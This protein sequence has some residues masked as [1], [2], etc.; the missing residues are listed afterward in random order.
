VPVLDVSGQPTSPFLGAVFSK[1]RQV[2]RPSAP[3][4]ASIALPARRL[5]GWSSVS[6][7]SDHSCIRCR[8][9]SP[10]GVR[11]SAASTGLRRVGQQPE[12]EMTAGM[13]DSYH[14]SV[15]IASGT[16]VPS[17]YLPGGSRPS[18]RYS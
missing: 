10:G 17:V 5:R 13:S 2:P 6:T 8:E 7:Q 3:V 4:S 14:G 15:A 11:W 1:A 9:T 16:G 12:P 18:R